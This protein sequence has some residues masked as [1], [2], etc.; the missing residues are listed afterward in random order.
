MS[1]M[2]GIRMKKFLSV[3]LSFILVIMLFLMGCTKEVETFSDSALDTSDTTEEPVSQTDVN[4]ADYIPT[5]KELLDIIKQ[6]NCYNA[7]CSMED[8]NR[9]YC[10]P[11]GLWQ[12]FYTPAPSPDDYDDLDYWNGHY[13]YVSITPTSLEIEMKLAPCEN[14]LI[15]EYDNYGNFLKATYTYFRGMSIQEKAY[16]CI[17]TVDVLCNVIFSQCPEEYRVTKGEFSN[18]EIK[19]L[20]NEFTDE[21]KEQYENDYG[22]TMPSDFELSGYETIDKNGIRYSFYYDEDKSS[23]CEFRI[24][25]MDRK[26]V[27]T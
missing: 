18:A 11:D 14:R 4:A 3:I 19:T 12:T 26:D 13:N 1:Y 24:F 21:V 5:P 7:E 2:K 25:N 27:L 22:S 8:L 6:S 17:P 9:N 20:N 10:T 16:S 15:V 23:S